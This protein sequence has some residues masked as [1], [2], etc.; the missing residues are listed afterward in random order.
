[1]Y[2]PMI[3]SPSPLLL[4]IPF[5]TFFH[6]PSI[7][8]SL[9][10]CSSINHLIQYT[11]FSHITLIAFPDR[12]FSILTQYDCTIQSLQLIIFYLAFRSRLQPKGINYY[13]SIYIYSRSLNIHL[14]RERGRAAPQG[15]TTNLLPILSQ[16]TLTYCVTIE[17]LRLRLHNNFLEEEE[18]ET[19]K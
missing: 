4:L 2:R 8:A 15:Q 9:H 6:L 10:R 5:S 17:T 14:E 12:D 13:I 1:M 11:P 3:S 19:R 7:V 18:E 16:H